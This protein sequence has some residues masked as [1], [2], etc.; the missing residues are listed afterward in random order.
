MGV[1]LLKMKILFLRYYHFL[2]SLSL[3]TK[4][5]LYFDDLYILQNGF[6]LNLQSSFTSILSCRLDLLLIWTL[7]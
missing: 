5:I 4:K 2:F 6:F 3:W 7:P 1:S